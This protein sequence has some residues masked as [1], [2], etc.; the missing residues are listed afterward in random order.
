M[1]VNISPV[2]SIRKYHMLRRFQYGKLSRERSMNDKR[3][4]MRTRIPTD[5][6]VVCFNEKKIPIK[7]RGIIVNA[8]KAG[9]SPE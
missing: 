8:R 3:T 7:I 2:A 9:F 4:P 6:I 5:I 1:K